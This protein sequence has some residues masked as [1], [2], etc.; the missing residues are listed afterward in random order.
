MSKVLNVGKKLNIWIK[1]FLVNFWN[2]IEFFWKHGQSFDFGLK[3]K[4][5]ESNFLSFSQKNIKLYTFTKKIF[6]L[7][8]RIKIKLTRKPKQQRNHVPV[9]L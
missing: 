6:K 2:F 3:L 1:K 8:I 7:I 5:E 9:P 4:F